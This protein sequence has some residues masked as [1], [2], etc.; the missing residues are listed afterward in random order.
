MDDK[1]RE[2]YESDPLAM[3]SAYGV[4]VVDPDETVEAAKSAAQFGWESLPGVG[5]T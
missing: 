4:D 2:V 3:A 1:L 5:T